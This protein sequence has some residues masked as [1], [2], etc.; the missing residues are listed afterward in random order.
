MRNVP[1]FTNLW[2]MICGQGMVAVGSAK[3]RDS[4]CAKGIGQILCHLGKRDNLFK[5]AL[6]VSDLH[7]VFKFSLCQKKAR[8]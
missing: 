1:L 2:P 4:R 5:A 3:C 8:T 7:H 6:L